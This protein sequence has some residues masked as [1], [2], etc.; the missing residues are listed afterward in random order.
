MCYGELLSSAEHRAR[1]EHRCGIC[2]K[3]IRPGEKYH[4]QSGKYEGEFY[5][6]KAHRRCHDIQAALWN[7]Y[8]EDMCYIDPQ[9]AAQTEA[10][11]NGWRG[12]L[13]MVRKVRAWRKS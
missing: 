5:T 12:L 10:K 3:A 7:R 6:T 2:G 11:E 1:K 9:E 13:A 4:Y 8:E